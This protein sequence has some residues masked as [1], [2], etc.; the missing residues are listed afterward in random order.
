MKNL[1]WVGAV[2]MVLGIAAFFIPIPHTEREGVKAG[3]MSL[4][5]ET[6]H[7][8]K[9][10]PVVGGLMIVAGAGLMIAGKRR[11]AR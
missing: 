8:E 7:E 5:I 2:L 3:G 11:R 6:R 9:L 4:S 10:P 1:L